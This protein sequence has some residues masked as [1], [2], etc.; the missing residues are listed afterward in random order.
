MLLLVWILWLAPAGA[1][2]LVPLPAQ[3]NGVPWPSTA[4]PE[5]PLPHEHDPA[6]L[7]AALDDLFVTTGRGGLPDTR[8]LLVVHRGR[9]VVE[10]YAPGFDRES[11]FHSWSMGKSVTQA[12]VGILVREGAL[13]VDEPAPLPAWAEP[14]DPRGGLT[15]RHLLHMNTGFDNADGGDGADTFVGRLLF[16]E[17]SADMATAAAGV[18]LAHD[19]GTHWAYSTG[20]S[21]LLGAIVSRSTGAERDATRDWLEKELLDPLGIQSLVAETDLTGQLVGG[22]H[23][24]ATAR[25]WARLGLLYLRDGLWEGRRILPAGWVDFTRTRAP[26]SNNGTYGAHFWIN[27]TPEE[28]QFK[29]VPGAPS[30]VFQMS[31]NGGQYVLLVP[32]RDLVVVRLGEMHALDWPSLGKK[33]GAL[34]SGFP[35]IAG[36]ARGVLP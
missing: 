18:P 17:G 29:P 23:V 24:W 3:P 1:Q 20:T 33:I 21:A 7:E 30:S 35:E 9:V 11:R 16:G 25:D 12:M 4:W 14:D 36:S 13:A 26:A 19:P 31:G 28:K 6:A 27:E 2:P 8:A 22:S 5:G 10:R 15:L 34:V 32:G